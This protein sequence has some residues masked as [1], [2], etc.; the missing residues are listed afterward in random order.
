MSSTNFV[1]TEEIVLARLAHT[2]D[3][4]L[5]KACLLTEARL[6]VLLR[7]TGSAAPY[8][9]GRGTITTEHSG[10]ELLNGNVFLIGFHMYIIPQSK[11]F[12]Q[13]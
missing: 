1:I 4:V 11:H 12:V 6:V 5:V 10:Q 2:R 9:N 13:Y 8:S 3:K 7:I